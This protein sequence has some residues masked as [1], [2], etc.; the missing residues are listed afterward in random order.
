MFSLL[1]K[2][3]YLLFTVLIFLIPVL[4]GSCSRNDDQD[5][6]E[7]EAWRTPEGITE[8]NSNG[9]IISED[10][11]DW[12][13]SPMYQGLVEVS[14]PAYP[15]PVRSERIY[16]ELLVSL[17]AVHGLEVYTF[18]DGINSQQAY[19][20]L[21][22]ENSTIEGLY[23]FYFDPVLFSP[24]GTYDGARGLHRVFIADRNNNLITYGD[25]KVE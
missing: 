23:E 24:S 11:D 17:D 6:F 14:I 13:M 15:N 25:I 2:Y 1:P 20:Q 18:P 5:E 9:E 10:P 7:R 21:H 12:R 22:Y 16:V 19:R 3:R 8:T 4:V